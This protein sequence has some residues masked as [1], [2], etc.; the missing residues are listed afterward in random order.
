VGCE[1]RRCIF[2][3]K[4]L[5]HA[6]VRAFGRCLQGLYMNV[7]VGSS[8]AGQGIHMEVVGPQSRIF[9]CLVLPAFRRGMVWGL[10][11]QTIGVGIGKTVGL[12][13]LL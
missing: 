7:V 1:T 5:Q 2:G 13:R 12:L 6:C 9:C 3:V 11:G 4:P 8:R 10:F